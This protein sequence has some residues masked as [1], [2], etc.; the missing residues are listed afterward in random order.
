MRLRGL[1]YVDYFEIS[2]RASRERHRSLLLPVPELIAW[3]AERVLEA[4][5]H[6]AMQALISSCDKLLNL[7]NVLHSDT[8]LDIRA[9]AAQALAGS[10]ERQILSNDYSSTLQEEAT[11]FEYQSKQYHPSPPQNVS[12]EDHDPS[13]DDQVELYW[14]MFRSMEQIEAEMSGPGRLE[15]KQFVEDSLQVRTSKRKIF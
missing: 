1:A 15:D 3:T 10:F 5:G 14:S 13:S 11:C 9:E 6:N 8:R 12:N 2:A 4:G 7:Q